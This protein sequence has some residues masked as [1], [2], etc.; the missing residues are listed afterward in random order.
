MIF[1]NTC[2]LRKTLVYEIKKFR[3]PTRHL[4]T[5]RDY[6]RTHGRTTPETPRAPTQRDGSPRSIL[7]AKTRRIDKLRA[8][9]EELE[10]KLEHEKKVNEGLKMKPESRDKNV[11]KPCVTRRAFV[12]N[13]TDCIP[14]SRS[15]ATSTTTT[16]WNRAGDRLISNIRNS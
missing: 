14:G 13:E 2:C 15:R 12:T 5:R 16:G 1:E 8:Q 3:D 10:K 6:A 11:I 7:A 4:I 9:N